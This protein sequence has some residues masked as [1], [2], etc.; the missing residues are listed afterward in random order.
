MRRNGDRACRDNT[1]GIKRIGTG[2]NSRCFSCSYKASNL[3]RVTG[4]ES[5]CDVRCR[6]GQSLSANPGDCTHLVC[7]PAPRLPASPRPS[8]ER[9]VGRLKVM[10]NYL[11]RQYRVAR[12]VLELSPIQYDQ[13]RLLIT[14]KLL[15]GRALK[16]EALGTLVTAMKAHLLFL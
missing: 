2:V 13:T 11:D 14:K 6:V 3:Y 12:Y 8:S 16:F 9:Q 7:S 1:G 15:K 10:Q 5:A 4:K